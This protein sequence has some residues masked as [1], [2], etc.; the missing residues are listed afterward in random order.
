MPSDSINVLF[1]AMADGHGGWEM[2]DAGNGW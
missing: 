1:S 2:A